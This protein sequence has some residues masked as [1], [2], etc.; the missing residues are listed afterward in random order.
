MKLRRTI[1]IVFAA[2][3]ASLLPPVAAQDTGRKVEIVPSPAATRPVVPQRDARGMPL[4]TPIQKPTDPAR[5]KATYEI[6]D[7]RVPITEGEFYDAYQRLEKLEP[8]TAGRPLDANRVYEHILAY[9]EAKALGLEATPEEVALFDPLAINQELAQATWARYEKDGIT[10][11]MYATYQREARTIQK[12]RDLFANNR[13]I[14]SSEIFETYRR[15]H[16]S[17]RLEYVEFPAER[18]AEEMR[19]TPPSDQELKAFWDEDKAT[20]NRFRTQSTVTAEFVSFDP[21]A[22]APS[23]GPARDVPRA[24]ALAY[25]TQNK[26][27]I[28]MLLTAEQRAMLYPATKVDIKDLPTP[29]QLLR[30]IIDREIQLSGKIR[31]AFEE[32]KKPGADFSA[33]ATAAGLT[34]ERI[35]AADRDAMTRSHARYGPQ[36][37][38]VLMAHNPGDVSPELKIEPQLQYFYRLV[39]KE[40]SK[41]PDFDSIKAKLIEPYSETT[42]LKRAQAAANAMRAWIDQQVDAE[43]KE[44]EQKMLADAQT[45]A[46]AEVKTRGVTQKPEIDAIAAR[47]KVN[48][49][50]QVRLKK[51]LLAPKY[52]AAYVKE[53]G[54]TVQDTGVFDAAGRARDKFFIKSN[55]QIRT[56]E[57]G[58]ITQVM[59]DAMTK[60]HL[61]ARMVERTEPDYSK[62][63]DGDLLAVR[64]QTERAGQYQPIQRWLFSEIS[65]RRDLKVQ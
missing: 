6:G 43:V 40:A 12:A 54:L 21:K 25:Y 23:N 4:P 16:Y 30:P 55:P 22:A 18:Y 28:D 65:R 53:H 62:M 58:Q 48:A 1:V 60:T 31:A 64:N 19:K 15:D 11:E 50:A 49:T 32:A 56:M 24:E 36:I 57:P 5:V 45:A 26:A 59:T 2:S 10:K 13:R 33:I 63:S 7:A 61:I 37:F 39:S 42:S 44:Y 17:F 47:H 9:A 29:F 38:S 41:L 34:Y 14:L 3:A 35:E 46:D 8:K 52:F 27:R 20:Q 51:D